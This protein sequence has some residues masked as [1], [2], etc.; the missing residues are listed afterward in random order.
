MNLNASAA[1]IF[2]VESP[3][4]LLLNTPVVVALNHAYRLFAATGQDLN[5]F[6]VHIAER[7]KENGEDES[8]VNTIGI[9]FSAKLPP[10]QKGIGNAS[11]LGRSVLYIASM[12]S[13]E[14]LREQG[15]R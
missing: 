14:I 11:K 2:E 4:Q 3:D 8:G 5:N 9:A 13:G 6:N 15:S 7:K 1:P 10:G 12:T